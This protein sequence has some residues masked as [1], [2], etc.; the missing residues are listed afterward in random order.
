MG[1]KAQDLLDGSAYDVLEADA[2]DLSEVNILSN[3]VD[4][5]TRSRT[6][7]LEAKEKVGKLIQRQEFDSALSELYNVTQSEL[8][9]RMWQ[10]LADAGADYDKA[11]SI[12]LATQNRIYRLV[13]AYGATEDTLAE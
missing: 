6:R 5:M 13:M 7:D 10:D 1:I 4:K 3:I 9:P 12:L 11:K 2:T 8:G